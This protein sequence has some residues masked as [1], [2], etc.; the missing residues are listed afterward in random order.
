MFYSSLSH[1]FSPPFFLM[2]LQTP[3]GNIRSNSSE[4]VPPACT[5]ATLK[6]PLVQKVDDIN[7]SAYLSRPCH[8]SMIPPFVNRKLEMPQDQ[9]VLPPPK[10]SFSRKW[11]PPPFSKKE[12]KQSA[13][14]EPERAKL[15]TAN[16][17]LVGF[18]RESLT[19]INEASGSLEEYKDQ[20][21]PKQNQQ[22]CKRKRATTSS[23]ETPSPCAIQ[24]LG[25]IRPTFVSDQAAKRTR[26]L[27]ER[28]DGGKI[29]NQT[30]A[31]HSCAFVTSDPR[32]TDCEMLNKEEQN[33]LLQKT[34]GA[35]AVM[36]TVVYRDGTSLLDPEQ[37]S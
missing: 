33:E 7:L 8:F 35:R 6:D 32:V 29:Q 24:S 12:A 16:T 37:V 13:S 17:E 25:K 26:T 15:A 2:L 1:Y 11:Q 4:I 5:S 36:L 34:K 30:K 23:R 31:S 20:P 22:P 18:P 28:T 14:F 27:H 10:I 9:R 19:R 21:A 3:N